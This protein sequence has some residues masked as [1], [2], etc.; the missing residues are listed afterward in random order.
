MT[1][2]RLRELFDDLA[3][4]LPEGP[5]RASELWRQGT[6]RRARGRW[7]AAAVAATVTALV[8]A[9][10]ALS[11]E[12]VERGITI[13][14]S[15]TPTPAIPPPPRWTPR[16]RPAARRGCPRWRRNCRRSGP[17]SPS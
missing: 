4:T 7:T 1:D 13:Y 16:R 2:Q 10:V 5:S 15:L 8:V 11:P 3:E 17:A 9:G 14:P 6:R 12:P